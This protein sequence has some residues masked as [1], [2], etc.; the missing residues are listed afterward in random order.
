MPLKTPK[1]YDLAKNRQ[2]TIILFSIER[3][4]QV[5]VNLP[6]NIGNALDLLLKKTP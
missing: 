6:Q 1:N 4:V 2:Y 5:G 3:N